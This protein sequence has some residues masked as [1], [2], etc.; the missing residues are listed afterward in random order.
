MVAPDVPGWAVLLYLTLIFVVFIFVLVKYP[1]HLYPIS[2]YGSSDE[3]R[4]ALTL[5]TLSLAATNKSAR[6]AAAATENIVEDTHVEALFAI[7][8]WRGGLIGEFIATLIEFIVKLTRG[9]IAK[10]KRLL[11]HMSSRRKRILWVDDHPDNNRLERIA[12][13]E[14]GIQ[15]DLARDTKEALDLLGRREYSAIISDFSRQNKRAGYQLL[16]HVR[17]DRT[18]N[19]LPFFVYTSRAA[20][21]PRSSDANQP[22]GWTNEPQE[23]F[24]DIAR[25]VLGSAG[26]SLAE[27]GSEGGA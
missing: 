20:R 5:G 26:A 11:S 1:S 7:S 12:F 18:A 9:S 8:P 21:A 6:D 14:I 22:E 10:S 16:D 23:L 13:R 4:K 25:H 24:E 3:F 17:Q 27:A 2:D 19:A 15:C